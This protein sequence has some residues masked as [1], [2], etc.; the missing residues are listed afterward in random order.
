[1][2]VQCIWP[3]VVVL[4]HLLLGVVA[5]NYLYEETVWTKQTWSG[6]K[7]SFPVH[8]VLESASRTTDHDVVSEIGPFSKSSYA[9]SSAG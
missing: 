6:F 4:G 8:K 5:V 7:L 9:D 1:M 3:R 2:P